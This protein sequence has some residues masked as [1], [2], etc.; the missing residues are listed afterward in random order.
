MSCFNT[1]CNI[2]RPSA[3][4]SVHHFKILF[5][6][7]NVLWQYMTLTNLEN[8]NVMVSNFVGKPLIAC[9]AYLQ[10]SVIKGGMLESG[11]IWVDIH[12]NIKKIRLCVFANAYSW[13]CVHLM[14]DLCT[15][16]IVFVSVTKI[17]LP[18]VFLQS[19]W[20]LKKIKIHN[21]DLSPPSAE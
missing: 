5:E 12:I 3:A 19:P 20:Y 16:M 14:F 6:I 15:C 1:Q 18:L 4:C 2:S 17:N 21:I 9:T 8:L 13:I 10:T 7:V 11:M